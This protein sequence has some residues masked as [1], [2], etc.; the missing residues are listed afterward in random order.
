MG[1]IK[2]VAV[3]IATVAIGLLVMLVVSLMFYTPQWRMT[4]TVLLRSEPFEDRS[5]PSCAEVRIGAVVAVEAERTTDEG[6]FFFVRVMDQRPEMA[7]R[8]ISGM[9]T[10]WT[11]S[12]NVQRTR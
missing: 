9:C 3:V 8:D 12:K 2:F 4:H 5:F 10:G 1:A 7:M 6:R 11:N